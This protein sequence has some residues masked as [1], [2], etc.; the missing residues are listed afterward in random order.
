MMYKPRIN[1]CQGP[2]AVPMLRFAIPIFLTA[3]LQRVFQAADMIL[4]GQLGT[5]GSDAVAAIGST[6]ALTS[7]LIN[8]FIGCST[9]SAVTVSHALGSRNSERLQK[10]VHTAMLLSLVLGAGLTALGLLSAR[11]LLIAMG[12]PQALLGLAST[13][14]RFYF[15]GMIPHMVYNFGAAIIRTTGETRKPLFYLLISGPVKLLLTVVFVS[16]LNMDVAGLALATTLSQCVSAALVCADLFRR[17]DTCRLR[18]RALKFSPEPLKQILRLGIPSGIQS[19]T[20][21]LS[22]VLVQ[23]S[24]NSLAHLSGF[25]AGNAA[26]CSIEGLAE[27]TTSAFY[28]VAL[29]FTGQNVGAGQ[30]DRV[31]KVYIRSCILCSVTICILSPI[32]LLFGRQL[33]GL[34]IVDS[35]EAIRWGMVRMTFLFTPLILQGLMDTSSGVLR[36]MGI[37]FSS[38]LITLVG[39]CGLRSLWL[40]TVFRLPQYHQPRILY[41]VYPI[42]WLI[43]FLG[44]LLL[45]FIVYKKRAQTLAS[46]H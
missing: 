9:G 32:V 40:L 46:S 23:S 2:I 43:T 45:F 24:V 38:T 39:I 4:A 12:T 35:E 17:K 36:G 21:S 29:N 25:I 37:S 28:T 42:S 30:Y 27:V 7:L 20:F 1:M 5:S 10:T 15:S 16:G 18:L 13:Y 33:L 44:E 34:Y 8:F 19:A 14:L 6:T 22:N 31:K 11:S 26:A 3:L 41:V